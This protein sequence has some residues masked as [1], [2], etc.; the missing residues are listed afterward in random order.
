MLSISD[1]IKILILDRLKNGEK[2]DNIYHYE[3]ELQI[4]H[5]IITSEVQIR[6]L[7]LSNRTENNKDKH[8]G[9]RLI[10]ASH[11]TIEDIL[12]FNVGFFFSHPRL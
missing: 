6:I 10:V 3:D 2:K 8:R 11:L 9:E 12:Y 7:T 4:L 1:K 5:R